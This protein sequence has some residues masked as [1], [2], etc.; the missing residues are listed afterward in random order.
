MGNDSDN[1]N[2]GVSDVMTDFMAC[3]IVKDHSTLG[4]L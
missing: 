4:E 3:M 1:S 2:L